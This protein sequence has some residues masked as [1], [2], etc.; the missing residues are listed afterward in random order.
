M[1][2]KTKHDHF[3]IR[4]HA[5]T[6]T[7]ESARCGDWMAVHGTTEA[8][9]RSRTRPCFIYVGRCVLA[10]LRALGIPDAAVLALYDKIF[11]Y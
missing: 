7:A 3:G 6:I 11:R 9:L 4:S 5:R 8:F 1:T 10:Q 2:V